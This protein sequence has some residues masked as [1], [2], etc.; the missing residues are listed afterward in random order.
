MDWS[1]IR[2]FKRKEFECH[3]GCGGADMNEQFVAALDMARK[4]SGIPFRVMS[5]YR[6]ERHNTNV[7]GVSESAH[8]RGY[9]ADIQT[10]GSAE[11]IALLRV[12]LK[13]FDRVG[14]DKNFIHV[15]CDP[16]K[17]RPCAWVY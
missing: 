8:T 7:G 4:D 10:S 15:D 11:R 14:V 17:P 3:C 1:K 13:Y 2:H 5:G 16:D 12:L 6:C 9:A